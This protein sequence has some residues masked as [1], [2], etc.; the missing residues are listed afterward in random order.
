MADPNTHVSEAMLHDL[1]EAFNK[2]DVEAVLA[3]MTDDIVFEG[4]AGPEAYG[5]RFVGHGEVG[6]AFA[7]VWKTFPN[8]QWKNHSHQVCGVLG[9]SQWTLVDTREDGVRIEADGVDL[10]T[11]KDGKIASKKAF[12]KERPLLED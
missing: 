6:A 10:F 7:G 11:F 12:R 4:A 3:F 2:H 1:F 8:V 9:V 5:A